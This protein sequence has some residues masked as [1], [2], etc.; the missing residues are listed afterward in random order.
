MKVYQISYIVFNVSHEFAVKYETLLNDTGSY[1]TL[2]TV[3]IVYT[4]FAIL[5]WVISNA[6]TAKHEIL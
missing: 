6:N 1:S 5:G 4:V 3:T 2:S